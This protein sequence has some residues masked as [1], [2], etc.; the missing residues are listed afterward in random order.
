MAAL[1]WREV[2]APDFT[3]AANISGRA[4]ETLSRAFATADAGLQRFDESKSEAVNQELLLEA[5]KIQDPAAYGQALPGMLEAVDPRRVSAE[6]LAA[7][8]Q[9]ISTRANNASSLLELSTSKTTADRQN[10]RFAAQDAAN[11]ILAQAEILA[12]AGDAAGANKLLADNAGILS[13]MQAED[14]RAGFTGIDSILS[15]DQELRDNDQAYQIKAFDFG[16]SRTAVARAEAADGAWM[17]LSKDALSY[18]DFEAAF[19]RDPA[20]RD[21][22]PTTQNAILE[23]GRGIYGGS[24]AMAAS[25]G[26]GGA[27][28]GMTVNGS[29]AGADIFN[30]VLGNGQFGSPPKPFSTMTG[31]EAIRFGREVLIPNTRGNRQLGLKPNEGSSAM[32]AY[33]FTG[34]TLQRLMPIVLRDQGGVNAVLTPENQEKMAEYLFNESKSG[35]LKAIWAGLPDA[36]PGAYANKTW[37]EMRDIIGPVEAGGRIPTMQ[38]LN[39]LGQTTQDNLARGSQQ[40]PNEVMLADYRKLAT[41]TSSAIVVARNLV[42]EGGALE[43]QNLGRVVDLIEQY[44]SN[45]GPNGI[46]KPAQAGYLLE[47]N[48]SGSNFADAFTGSNLGGGLAI[49]RRGIEADREY[50]NSARSTDSMAV[51]R[52]RQEA[53]AALPTLLAAV[54]QAELTRDAALARLGNRG[55]NPATA[56]RYEAAVTQARARYEDA[57]RKAQPSGNSGE[58]QSSVDSRRNNRNPINAVETFVPGVAI[59]NRLLGR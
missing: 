31:A 57:L 48:A 47:T 43:G 19:Y 25:S 15:G 37:A 18:D 23:R 21:L 24:A 16:Q 54:T 58:A 17:R 14:R 26:G 8:Q 20:V 10:R 32:G 2:A 46:V 28:A 7:L 12:N 52:E 56:A 38:E 35:N 6:T 30:T 44:S 13:A 40:D 27:S 5:M 45:N 3:S 41:D 34:G 50:L 53:S 4:A 49:N 55:A 39:D 51:I 33:Q 11:P 22:D 42:A 36:R 9:G 59:L 1:T 29:T